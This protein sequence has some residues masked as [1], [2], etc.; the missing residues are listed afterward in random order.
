MTDVPSAQ[1]VRT[2]DGVNIAYITAGSGQPIVWIQPPIISHVQLEWEQP[3][4]RGGFES[5]IAAGG[6]LIRFDARG[7]GLS[8]RHANE[9]SPEA[10]A[11]DLEAVVE[12]LQLTSFSILAIEH[13]ASCAVAY[14]VLHPER[15]ARLILMNPAWPWRL[16]HSDGARQPSPGY[17]R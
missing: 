3:P 4:L 6:M 13:G 14:A 11:R 10:Y 15:V 8:D 2:S 17:G 9:Y 16:A 1:Y 12:H 7:T 5:M